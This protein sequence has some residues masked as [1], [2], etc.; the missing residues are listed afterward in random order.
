MNKHRVTVLAL[1]GVL[2]ID[3]GIPTQIFNARPDT[4]YELT[5]CGDTEEK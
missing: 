1:D 5:V 2:P 4:P 3:L